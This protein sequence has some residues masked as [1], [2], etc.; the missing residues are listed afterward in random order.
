[1]ED[2]SFPAIANNAEE[3][4]VSVRWSYEDAVLLAKRIVAERPDFVYAPPT[5][6]NSPTCVYFE[7]NKPSC[8]VGH[9]LWESGV[10]DMGS[11]NCLAVSDLIE[12]GAIECDD[13]TAGFLEK[14]Q[15]QQDTKHSWGD[16]LDSALRLGDYDE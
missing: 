11:Y 15:A 7:H 6:N 3:K 16:S 9:M 14:L 5:V 13:E 8:L 2:Q 4:S 1:V 10:S 12:W